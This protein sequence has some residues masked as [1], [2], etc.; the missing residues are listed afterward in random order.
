MKNKTL[1][2]AIDVQ[3][4][5][6]DDEALGVPGAKEDVKRIV[7]FIENNSDMITDITVSID[8]HSPRQIFHPC[9]WVDS[10]GDNPKPYTVITLEDLDKGKYE[11]IDYKEESYDYVKNLEKAGKKSLIIW[12]YHC[13]QSTVGAA[14]E[15]SFAK[16]ITQMTMEKGV[17][18]NYIIKGQDPLSEMYGIIKPEYS[19]NPN[20]MN[21]ELLES[22]KEY[23]K[24]FVVGEAKSHCVLE[25]VRQI[26]EYYKDDKKET[27]K[28]IILQDC[29]S[30]IS[31]FEE[32]TEKTFNEFS[33][34][35]GVVIANSRDKF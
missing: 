33:K 8:T 5:F 20:C 25:S 10:N 29:M 35:Y 24:I 32:S 4:D 17:P 7:N 6:M 12:P 19:T 15:D 2:L 21:I 13:L 23:E 31:G 28:Y 9:W 27:Q 22:F 30:S 18:V 1:L 26:L 34:E 3:N 16:A 11:A 14:L